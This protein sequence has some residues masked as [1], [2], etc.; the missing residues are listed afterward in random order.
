MLTDAE[1]VEPDGIGNACIVE[2]L[3]H[4]FG[5]G[6]GYARNRIGRQVRKG[7]DSNFHF[8][9]APIAGGGCPADTC[10]IVELGNEEIGQRVA[11]PGEQL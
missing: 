2:Q 11:P 9:S 4:A 6:D 3:A 1:D 8:L 10:P 7:I 5:R